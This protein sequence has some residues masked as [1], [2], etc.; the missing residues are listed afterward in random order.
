MTDK[1]FQQKKEDF[2][3]EVCSVA[4]KGNGYTNHCPSC[5]YSKHVDISPGD[6]KSYCKGLMKPIGKD[7]TRKKGYIVIHKCEKCG[8]IKRNKVSS[9]DNL[10][11]LLRI[12][13][14]ESAEIMKCKVSPFSIKDRYSSH[15]IFKSG[16]H[17][18]SFCTS[19]HVEELSFVYIVQEYLKNMK[20]IYNLSQP[21]WNK[22]KDNLFN[23]L[24]RNKVPVSY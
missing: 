16:Y 18:R 1:K 14:N 10:S 23:S 8:E 24:K 3:C 22:F 9:E 7:Y 12:T 2:C 11:L 13:N 4:V 5:F 21:T 15:K 17:K 6:R 19:S 20:L